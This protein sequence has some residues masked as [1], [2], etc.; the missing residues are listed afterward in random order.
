MTSARRCLLPVGLAFLFA[1]LVG[2]RPADANRAPLPIDSPWPAPA[3]TPGDGTPPPKPTPP[4]PSPRPA[5]DK[6][7]SRTLP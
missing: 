2:T 3:T 4:P 7:D 1:A 5:F 6:T